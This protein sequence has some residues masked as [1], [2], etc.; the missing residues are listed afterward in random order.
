VALQ[1][2]LRGGGVVLVVT[3]GIRIIV[4]SCR[5]KA[6]IRSEVRA[7]TVMVMVIVGRNEE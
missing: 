7:V 2:P 6:V 4:L 1:S 5:A 3:P